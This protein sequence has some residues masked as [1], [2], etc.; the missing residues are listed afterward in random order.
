M[1]EF[2]TGQLVMLKSV[3]PDVHTVWVWEDAESQKPAWW[4]SAG[5]S[6]SRAFR[7]ETIGLYLGLDHRSRHNVLIEDQIWSIP[8]DDVIPLPTE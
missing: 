5:L 6:K 4:A 2:E 1:T 8:K 3:W 7:N